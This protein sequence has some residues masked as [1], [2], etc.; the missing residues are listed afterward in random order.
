MV[1][2]LVLLV[3]SLVL[4]TRHTN[5]TSQ[6]TPGGDFNQEGGSDVQ[7]FP[8]HTVDQDTERDPEDEGKHHHRAHDVISQEFP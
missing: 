4:K 1:V 3:K 7:Q 6:S 5:G 8:Y 2:L